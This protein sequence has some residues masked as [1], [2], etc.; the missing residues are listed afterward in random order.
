MIERNTRVHGG[1]LRLPEVLAHTGLPRSTIYAR[2][3][4]GRFPRWVSPGARADG[5]IKAEVDECIRER[6]ETSRGRD[7]QAR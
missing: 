6:I 1:F 5:W 3:D 2:L 7:V 4:Q